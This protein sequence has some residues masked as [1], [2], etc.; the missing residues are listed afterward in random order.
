MRAHR[1][2][3]VEMDKYSALTLI[4]N[5]L[6]GHKKWRPH[7]RNPTLKPRYDVVIIGGG[8]HGLATAYYLAKKHGISNVA[9]LEKGW[10]GGGN[11]G[12]NTQAIRSNYFYREA[13]E[14][15]DHSLCL[16]EKL[17]EEL[18]SKIERSFTHTYERYR[19]ACDIAQHCKELFPLLIAEDEV[20]VAPAAPGVAEIGQSYTG[21]PIFSQVWNLIHVPSVSVPVGTGPGNMPLGLQIIAHCGDESRAFI[22]AEWVRRVLAA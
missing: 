8:G 17:S 14:F 20:V 12:R 19:W 11:T 16:Y 15:F 5:G 1:D 21:S 7:W 18:T 3:S 6:S 13:T 22:H 2:N 9:V 10:L 4:K